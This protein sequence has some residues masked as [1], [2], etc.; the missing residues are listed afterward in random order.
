MRLECEHGL[1]Y[2]CSGMT[3]GLVPVGTENVH[4]MPGDTQL[5][6]RLHPHVKFT[7]QPLGTWGTLPECRWPI[8][9][10]GPIATEGCASAG[11]VQHQPPGWF[12]CTPV[13]GVWP[14]LSLLVVCSGNWHGL[15]LWLL[16]RH[17]RSYQPRICCGPLQHRVL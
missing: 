13:L 7:P 2:C 6:K 15:L 1:S 8:T 17:L 16:C 3:P 10:G 12:L 14:V 9:A 11:P 5:V 4:G